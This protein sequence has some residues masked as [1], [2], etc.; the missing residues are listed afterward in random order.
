MFHAEVR[1]DNCDGLTAHDIWSNGSAA[2]GREGLRD[3]AVRLAGGQP[4]QGRIKACVQE[5]FKELSEP[6]QAM[7]VKAVTIGKACLADVKQNCP[8]VKAGGGRIAACMKSH[9]AD[10][11]Q[12]CKDALSRAVAGKT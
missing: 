8:G 3:G 7:L 1:F 12:D 10:V 11:S 5:H 4:G 9:L 2:G 6:C